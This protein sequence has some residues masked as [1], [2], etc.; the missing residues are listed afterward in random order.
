MSTF[1]VLEIFEISNATILVCD[2]F[3]DSVVTDTLV[4]D[5]GI[6]NK[7]EFEVERA[8]ACFSEPKSRIVGIRKNNLPPIH[9]IR[10]K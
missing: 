7:E 3:D 8:T 2:L 4:T 1:K 5:V 6:F 9:E 10:F